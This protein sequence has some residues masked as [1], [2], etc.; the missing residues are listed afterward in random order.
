MCFVADK[1]SSNPEE[2]TCWAREPLE[3][4]HG[5]PPFSLPSFFAPGDNA[6]N[7]ACYDKGCN[8]DTEHWKKHKYDDDDGDDDDVDDARDGWL[9]AWNNRSI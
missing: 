5:I 3:P 6:E 8:Y 2:I 1:F 9:L 4:P 7:N